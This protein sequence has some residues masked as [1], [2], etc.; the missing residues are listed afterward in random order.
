MIMSLDV[1]CVLILILDVCFCLGSF[2]CL[3][4]IVA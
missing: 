4:V 1:F 2:S 3:L